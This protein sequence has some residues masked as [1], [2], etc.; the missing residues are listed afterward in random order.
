MK[1]LFAEFMHFFLNKKEENYTM[2]PL[3]TKIVSDLTQFQS[4]KNI[5]RKDDQRYPVLA[6]E[7]SL[8]FS[9]FIVH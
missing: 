5:K 3:M 1:I 9:V 4:L 7:A 6:M 8:H 2:W